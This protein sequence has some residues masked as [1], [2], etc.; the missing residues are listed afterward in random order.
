MK[1]IPNIHPGEVLKEDFL[2]PM[3]INYYR[4]S[5]EIGIPLSSTSQIIKGKRRITPDTAKRLSAFFGNTA[6]FWLGIQKDYDLEEEEA[7]T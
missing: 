2:D 5:E 3:D 7:R 4:L 1:T 6:E